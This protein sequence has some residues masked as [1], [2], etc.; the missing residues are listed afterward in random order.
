MLD[1]KRQNNSLTE[2]AM[3]A[4]E[5][6][7][8]LQEPARRIATLQGHSGWV[9]AVAFAPNRNLLASG[10]VDGTMHL[11]DFSTGHPI[12][13]PLPPTRRRNVYALAFSPDSKTLAVGSG[14]PN[15]LIWLWDVSE[16]PP[17]EKATLQ[18]HNGPVNALAFSPDGLSL[19]SGGSDKTVRLWKWAEVSQA[20]PM[21]L[22]GHADFLKSVA[23]APDGRTLASGSLDGTARLWSVE[24][25]KEMAALRGHKNHVCSVAFAHDSQLLASG[26]PDQTIRLWNLGG[27]SPKTKSIISDLKAGVQLVQFSPEG[28]TLLSV[29]DRGRVVLWEPT[30]GGKLREWI[31]ARTLICSLAS[32]LD[33]RYLATGNTDGTVQVYRLYPKSK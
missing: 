14:T 23:F 15:G 19:A 9:T 11:W 7:S 4:A 27:S 3:H 17:R 33:G 29:L 20:Q 30:T 12:E 10:G 1:L 8:G 25:N 26:G 22:Q 18:G 32:T 13:R 21:I 5:L 28:G 2:G 16:N 31:I 24:R 6:S